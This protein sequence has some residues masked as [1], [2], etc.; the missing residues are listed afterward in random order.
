MKQNLLIGLVVVALAG[1]GWSAYTIHGL[2]A[3]VKAL[4]GKTPSQSHTMADVDYQFSNLWF[5]GKSGNWPL[6]T[7]YLNETRSH[8]EWTIRIFPVRKLSNGQPLELA[9]ILKTVEDTGIAGLKEAIGRQDPTAFE[10]A[11]R[12]MTEQCYSC[13]EAAEKPF[14]HPHIPDG[15][16]TQMINMDPKADWP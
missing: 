6:A 12:S 8:L 5:A 1:V 16:S 2:Q 10:A 7:F 14:L 11:Y 4:S 13:H 3:D 15:P 9:P